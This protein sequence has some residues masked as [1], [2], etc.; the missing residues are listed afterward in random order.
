[1]STA[2]IIAAIDEA[3]ENW[4]GKPVSLSINGRIV[5]YRSLTELIEARRY[6]A[7]LQAAS[8]PI[9]GSIKIAQFKSGGTI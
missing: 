6:Y 1:M 7:S 3:I 9:R 2:T 4:V 8:G 5:T